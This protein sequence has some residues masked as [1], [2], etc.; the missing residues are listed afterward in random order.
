MYHCIN[1]LKEQFYE[2][3]INSD[4]EIAS[5]RFQIYYRK[6]SLSFRREESI[7]IENEKIALLVTS[8]D[9]VLEEIKYHSDYIV[10]LAQLLHKTHH[11]YCEPVHRCRFICKAILVSQSRVTLV[12]QL[13]ILSNLVNIF[14]PSVMA[15]NLVF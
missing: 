14:K 9:F 5:R 7:D 11:I 10:V 1:C 3:Y 4:E 6:K 15:L 8:F 13:I 2:K 12:F